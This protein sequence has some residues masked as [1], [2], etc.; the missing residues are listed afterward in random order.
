MQLTFSMNSQKPLCQL[1]CD[2]AHASG[3]SV[4]IVGGVVRDLLLGSQSIDNDMD[5]LIDGDALDFA[6]RVVQV[7]GGDLK[8]FPAFLTAKIRHPALFPTIEE[9]DFASSRTEVY[10]RPGAL[11]KVAPATLAQDLG[12]RDISINAMALPVA[13]L[14]QA[15]SAA[16]HLPGLIDP[17]H[18]Q[19]DLREKRIRILHQKSFEDDPTRLFRVMRYAGRLDGTLEP[20]TAECFLRSVAAGALETIS[21]TRIVN[22]MVKIL[23]EPRAAEILT[24][25]DEFGVL[26]PVLKNLQVADI[27][28]AA[29]LIRNLG[30]LR[31]TRGNEPA[32][33][34]RQVLA[35]LLFL[36]VPDH[37]KVAL[38]RCMQLSKREQRE[39]EAGQS[40]LRGSGSLDMLSDAAVIAGIV[41]GQRV[42]ELRHIAR[43]RGVVAA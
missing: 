43:A 28:A 10:E 14:L 1:L 33:L 36:V 19:Q 5:F 23:C 8:T 34:A 25:M 24:V 39:V 9:L 22:E 27:A 16:I 41:S 42:D 31:W 20:Q 17:F 37:A 29:S 7:S 38:V 3:S 30:T 15:G 32:L 4:Y 12:R 35:H 11:P 18:G 13:S 40:L 26:V 21:A 2:I 6:T